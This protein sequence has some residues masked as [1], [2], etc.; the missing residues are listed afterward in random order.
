MTPPTVAGLGDI[1]PET[2][3]VVPVLIKALDDG[4]FKVGRNAIKALN[5]MELA[6]PEA[7]AFFVKAMGKNVDLM[8]RLLQLAA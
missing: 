1:G 5:D 8:E 2:K 6:A 3:D 4:P 7:I